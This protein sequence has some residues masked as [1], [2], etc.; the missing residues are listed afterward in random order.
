MR[1]CRTATGQ[2]INVS[3]TGLLIRFPAA[4]ADDLPR[5]GDLVRVEVQS[6]ETDGPEKR[7][8]HCDGLVIRVEQD[9][10]EEALLGLQVESMRFRT[11]SRRT[12]IRLSR[13]KSPVM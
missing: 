4:I 8:L 12:R 9:R 2:T 10:N 1:D 5:P 3:R 7:I 11:D 6:P 13:I